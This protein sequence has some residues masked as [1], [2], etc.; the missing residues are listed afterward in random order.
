MPDERKHM[1]YSFTKIN[2][3]SPF[4]TTQ[5]GHSCQTEKLSEFH[6]PLYA[7]VSAFQN[8]KIWIIH[9]SFDLLAFDLEHRNKLEEKLQ[10]YYQ[11]KRIR[12]ITSATHTHYANSVRDPEYVKY[13]FDLLCQETMKMEYREVHDVTTTYQRLHTTAIG[14]SR[15]SAYETGLENLC[16]IRFYEEEKNFFNIIYYNCHP[17]ILQA[18]VPYFSAEYPGYVLHKLEENDPDC[19]FTFFQGAAGDISSRFVRDGQDYDALM[20]LGDRLYD[21]ILS[22]MN[23]NPEKKALTLDYKE[24]PIRYDH[25]F[26]P[27]DLSRIRS[28]LSER[29]ME[30]IRLG[31]IERAKLEK[32]ANMIFGKLIEEA[33][34][35]SLDL[36]SVKIIFF[37]N[38]I[39]SHYMS[40]IDLDK[41]M[42]VSYSNGY[43]PYV[44][45]IDFEYITYE[46]FTDTLTRETKEK[47]I[48]ILQTI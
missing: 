10:E 47:I 30:T 31:Q 44:L 12:V 42:L 28:D 5:C 29:E 33:L 34:I 37:P 26:R 46:M 36:G 23:E 2:I 41:E 21:D 3:N 35:V 27:I 18:N 25:E 8:D 15:I 7:R 45:P 19:D 43:G 11:D 32:T 17:T 39:F 9:Y 4:P 24:V 16:L 40:Y 13:L 1:K 20:K 38:E 22:L 6:D 14:K 48:E